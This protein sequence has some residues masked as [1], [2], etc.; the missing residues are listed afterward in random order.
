MK[1]RSLYFLLP[2]YLLYAENA[3]GQNSSNKGME[4]LNTMLSKFADAKNLQFEETRESKSPFNTDTTL[5]NS[6]YIFFFDEQGFIK[7]ADITTRTALYKNRVII[8][9]SAAYFYDFEDS[10][11]T[12]KPGSDGYSGNVSDI[13]ALL[14]SLKKILTN[15]PGR[16]SLKKDT[17]IQHK[18]CYVVLVNSFDSIIDGRRNFTNQTIVIDKKSYL[19][20]MQLHTGSGLA[21]KPGLTE[22]TFVDFYEKSSYTNIRINELHTNPLLTFAGLPG[23]TPYVPKTLLSAGTPTPAWYGVTVQGDSV[24]SES[25]LGKVV[26]LY[27]SGIGCPA[28]QASI[29]TINHIAATFAPD[30]FVIFGIYD[31]GKKSLQTYIQQHSL[32]YPIIFN[33]RA[34]KKKFNAPGSPYFYILD[35]TGNVAYAQTGWGPETEKMLTEKIRNLLIAP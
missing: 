23:F 32:L 28:A 25:G 17:V 31:D 34:I 22:F 6:R 26:L 8:T 18:A 27:L 21:E 14:Y 2:L 12:R 3:Y 16:V 4:I 20:L 7:N 15:N 35:K 13:G 33:G 29:R 30:R 1:Q 24:S 9:D 5:L 11:Y 19:P 10:T